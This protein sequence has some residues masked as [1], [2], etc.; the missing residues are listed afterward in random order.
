V[1]VRFVNI[2]G[3]VDHDCLTFFHNIVYDQFVKCIS[4]KKHSLLFTHNIVNCSMTT[5]PLPP[6]KKRERDYH[7]LNHLFQALSPSGI[8]N[9]IWVWQRSV[10]TAH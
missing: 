6:P 4:E 5:L 8:D 1:I 3:I 2:D 9:L 7:H 10:S